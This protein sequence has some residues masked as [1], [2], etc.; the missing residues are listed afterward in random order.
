VAGFTVGAIDLLVPLVFL[1]LLLFVPA[2][3]VFVFG[4]RRG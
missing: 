1:F 3:L 4:R 2:V